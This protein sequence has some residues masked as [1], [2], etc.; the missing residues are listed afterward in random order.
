M[1]K[2]T[3]SAALLAAALAAS[4]ALAA[5][6]HAHGGHQASGLESL[7]LNG[8]SRWS[9]D[10]PLRKGMDGIRADVEA[11]LPAIHTQKMDAAGFATLAAKVQGHVDFMVGNCKLPEAV[12]AQAHVILEQML[13]GIQTMEKAGTD[14]TA[15]AV[16][17]VAALD[18]YGRFFDHPGW[19]APKH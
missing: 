18:A 3:L 16:R 4:P 17:I 12:D 11:A 7:K 8:N 13:A 1:F 14:R 5:D 10:A 6:D 15:G 19:S 2:L 9:T